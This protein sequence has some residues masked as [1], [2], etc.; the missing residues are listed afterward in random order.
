MKTYKSD[1]PEITLK[2]KTG[3][4]KKTKIST[5]LDAFQVLLQLY[6]D[7]TLDYKET[8]Y[9]LFLNKANNTIGW[10]KI[11]EGGTS[12]T[13]IDQKI[14]FATALKCNASGIILSHNH[15]SGQLRASD[16]DRKMTERIVSIGFILGIE[17]LDHVIVC[18]SGY[19]SMN[20][21]GEM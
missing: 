13:I 9:A 20:D 3:N 19:Y 2:Y 4:Y 5:S 16:E 7:D 21:E 1:M 18:R 11:S 10:M 8:A 6:D 12:S 17:V 15:P 14:I